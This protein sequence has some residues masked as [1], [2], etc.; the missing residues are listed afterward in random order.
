[1]TDF[2]KSLQEISKQHQD[3]SIN[4]LKSYT[5]YIHQLMKSEAEKGKYR[6]IINNTTH[7]V[8]IPFYDIIIDLFLN[9]ESID[10]IL[11]ETFGIPT[12]TTVDNRGDLRNSDPIVTIV[13]DWS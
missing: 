2:L 12:K 11:T 3:K 1:M 8:L 6:L 5:G 9:G 13:F 7:K 4:T 10:K